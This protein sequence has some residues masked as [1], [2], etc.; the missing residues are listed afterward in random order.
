MKG[1]II[2]LLLAT[3]ALAARKPQWTRQERAAPHDQIDIRFALKQRNL[4][5]LTTTL[6]DVS[7]PDSVNY[8]KW[9]SPEEILD[10]VAPAQEVSE[11]VAAFVEA[12]GGK[13]VKNGRDYVSAR[14]TVKNCEQFFGIELHSYHHNT[15]P[16]KIIRAV[17]EYAIPT[18]IKEHVDF[19]SGLYEFPNLRKQNHRPA[20][21]ISVGDEPGYVIPQTIQTAYNIP[22][23]FSTN[24]NSSLCLAEFQNDQSFNK[25]DLKTFATQTATNPIDVT[26]IVGPFSGSS[27]DLEST[28]D[29]QYGG[30]IALGND[31]W[32]WTVGGW[33]YEFASEIAATKKSP[34]VVSMS[35][36]W[37]EPNQCDI[38]TCNSNSGTTSE[39]YV[40]RVN[41]EFQK[42]GLRGM[43]LLAASGDQGAPGD[44]DPYCSDADAPLSTIF[45]GASPWVLSVGATMLAN[46]SSSTFKAEVEPPICKSFTCADTTAEVA[47]SYP[48]ALITS[49]GGFSNYVP[50]PSFQATV[51][52]A[53]L[54]SAKL[55]PAKYFNASNR[56]FPDVSALGHN[57]LICAS[58]SF[59]QVDG[60]SCSS[61]VFGAVI[62]LLNSWRLNNNKAPLGYAVPLMYKA[63]AADP[64]TFIDITEG[65]N[66]C[67]ESCCSQYGYETA[68]GWD[69]VTGLGSP[70]FPALLKYVQS[71]P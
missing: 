23:N 52:D 66:K 71:L 62:S 38:A 55:P 47:C 21:D 16:S 26:H 34:L 25:K 18:D 57:Y 41:V 10:L 28:L 32:F 22:T 31:I 56:G 64:T 43:T 65:D 3:L 58:G 44:D 20:V 13:H 27:P 45:P 63:Y 49:G 70:N 54:K 2:L 46:T 36:G 53:Y 60:T 42:M 68:V 19:V 39:Q 50:Q 15:K 17:N 35:W 29:V 61:P 6:L 11:A 67:T 48:E 33:M 5:V 7:D 12:N 14:M 9:W 30:A 59:E 8:G 37:P 69:P 51:V 4:N 24:A 1:I 40:E